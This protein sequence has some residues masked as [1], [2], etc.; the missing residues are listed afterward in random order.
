MKQPKRIFGSM[1]VWNGWMDVMGDW[2]VFH[3]KQH[4]CEKIK[5]KLVYFPR[6]IT[7]KKAT[8]KLSSII[9]APFLFLPYRH[10]QV[11]LSVF[12]FQFSL[13]I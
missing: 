3:N 9:Y 5:I 7:F 11:T 10:R 4:K 2:L 6:L 8:K 13:G 1:Y 12:F